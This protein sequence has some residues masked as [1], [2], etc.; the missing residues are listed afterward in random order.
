MTSQ[1]S[2]ELVVKDQLKLLSSWS[3]PRVTLTNV[4]LAT[5]LL[6]AVIASLGTGR[7]SISA[8]RI[9]EILMGFAVNP[10]RAASAID[11]RIVLLVRAPR[12]LLAAFCGA[13]LAVAGAAL[14]G[15]F[16]N[17]LVAPQILGISPGAAF[18]D[19][20]SVV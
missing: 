15:V 18:G 2:T 20:K 19:R 4:A 8:A 16:R 9:I 7:F 14:Q 3:T 10:W 17:P 6:V 13:G 5:I 12:V 1:A 11:E